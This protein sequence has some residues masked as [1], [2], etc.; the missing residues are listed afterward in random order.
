MG[1]GRMPPEDLVDPVGLLGRWVAAA[2][3]QASSRS[4]RQ[5][6]YSV[7]NKQNSFVASTAEPNPENINNYEDMEYEKLAEE[8]IDTLVRLHGSVARTIRNLENRGTDTIRGKYL[9]LLERIERILGSR[10]ISIPP[11]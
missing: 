10:E 1:S 2:L 7:T 9:S 11:R 3:P 5:E 8:D 4:R 6:C